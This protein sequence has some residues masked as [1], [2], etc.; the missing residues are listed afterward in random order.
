MKKRWGWYN[1]FS[2]FPQCLEI[3]LEQLFTTGPV[4]QSWKIVQIDSSESFCFHRMFLLTSK[5]SSPLSCFLITK[6]YPLPP[7]LLYTQVHIILPYNHFPLF[8]DIAVLLLLVQALRQ[9]R[10]RGWVSQSMPKRTMSKSWR[11]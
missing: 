5:N 9:Q 10:I 3:I 7:T 4:E 2:A 6:S 1:G 8:W 11:S